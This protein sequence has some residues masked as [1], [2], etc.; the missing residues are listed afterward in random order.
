MSTTEHKA[1]HTPGPWEY[2]R[3]NKTDKTRV[4]FQIRRKGSVGLN[5]IVAFTDDK[6]L[7]NEEHVEADAKLI[8][9]A[10]DLLKALQGVVH[11]NNGLKD[12]LS[13]ALMRHVESAIAKATS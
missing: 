5:E 13:P 3:C 4:E 2:N 1:T 6:A 8:A 7:Y 9:A 10:P 12:K 11:H